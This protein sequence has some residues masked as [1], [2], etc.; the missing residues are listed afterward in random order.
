ML[1]AQPWTKVCPG[2]SHPLRLLGAGQG[3]VWRRDR[4][5]DRQRASQ[6]LRVPMESAPAP[7]IAG[8]GE[9]VVKRHSLC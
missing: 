7:V 4:Q 2:F 9:L 5:T 6:T 3:S 1:A 8:Q